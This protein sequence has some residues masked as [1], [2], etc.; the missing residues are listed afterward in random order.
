MS[1]VRAVAFNFIGSR[2]ISL[3]KTAM[4]C[5]IIGFW[6]EKSQVYVEMWN[7]IFWPSTIKFFHSSDSRTFGV[8]IKIN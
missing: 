2:T 8:C 3:D 6:N 4:Y 7:W 5:Y 1:I